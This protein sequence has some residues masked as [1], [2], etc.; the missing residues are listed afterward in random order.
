[1]IPERMSLRGFWERFPTIIKNYTSL[2]VR[3]APK[4]CRCHSLLGLIRAKRINEESNQKPDVAKL[5]KQHGYGQPLG[6]CEKK[7]IAAEVTFG[8][9]LLVFEGFLLL[10]LT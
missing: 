1:M 3:W 6:F 9:V 2:L 7:T 4:T 8:Q 10:P 5:L